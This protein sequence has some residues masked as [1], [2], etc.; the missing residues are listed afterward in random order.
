[1]KLLLLKCKLFIIDSWL[2]S[3]CVFYFFVGESRGF[4]MDNEIVASMNHEL[5]YAMWTNGLMCFVERYSVKCFLY[6]TLKWYF[7][8]HHNLYY[9]L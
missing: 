6:K 2:V 1:M 3:L 9:N 8:L 4:C 5:R 7:K